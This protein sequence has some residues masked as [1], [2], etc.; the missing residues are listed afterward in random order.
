MKNSEVF[1][2]TYQEIEEYFQRELDSSHHLRFYEMVNRMKK[3]S[4]AVRRYEFDLREYA[5]LRNAITHGN[6]GED[7]AIAEPH[8]KVVEDLQKIRDQIV[9]PP[10]ITKIVTHD[11]KT[12]DGSMRFSDAL[13]LMKEHGYGQLP[14]YEEEQYQGIFNGEI[15]MRWLRSN[16]KREVL[17]MNQ[18]TVNEIIDSDSAQSHQVIFKPRAAS[19]LDIQETVERYTDKQYRLQAIIIT[20]NGKPTEKPLTI[21]TSADLPLIFE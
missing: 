5:D 11:V 8:D 9:A 12:I 3:K 6:M 13:G 20:E 1:L 4:A 7:V 14:V 17:K 19:V 18:V 16:H 2:S 15:V 21:I 10:V